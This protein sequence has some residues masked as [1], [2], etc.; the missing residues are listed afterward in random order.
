MN[1]NDFSAGQVND[2][3]K[4]ASNKLGISPE[5]LKQQLESGNLQ[6]ALQK[7]G[8]RNAAKLQ[9]IL[10]DPQLSQQFLSD[11]KVLAKLKAIL[12]QNG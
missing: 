6:N 5:E 10:S 9:K 2:M 4:T 8:P 7:M 12:G 3:L 1:Q 11:P